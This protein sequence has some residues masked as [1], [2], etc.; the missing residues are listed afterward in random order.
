MLEIENYVCRIL[1]YG[2]LPISLR[3]EGV[4]Y[5]DVIHGWTENR[6]MSLGKTNAKKILAGFGISQTNPYLV[7]K[8]FHFASLTD[9]YWMMEEGE[10]VLWKDVSL[11]RNRLERAVSST[12][13]L[14]SARHFYGEKKRIRQ[15][16][17]TPELTAQG[18]S[19]KAW[20]RERGGMYL[21]KVGKKELAASRILD[22]LGIS[23]VGDE[24]V[25]EK[26]LVR[27]ADQKH[28]DKIKREQEKV[29]RCRMITSEQRAI[30]SWEDFQMYCA[31]HDIDEY[32][33]VRTHEARAYYSMQIADYILAY[34]DRHGANFGFF[35]NNRSGRLGHLYP[36]MDHDH[37]FSEEEPIFCQ[38]SEDEETLK[39]A[40][41][42]AA[43]QV[44]MAV[45][46]QRV[47][48]MGKPEEITD[49]Q[50]AGVLERTRE[51]VKEN[52]Q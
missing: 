10:E 46:Y 37:A 33:Y 18:M 1:D 50:W 22:A 19:A 26:R 41:L 51:L 35:M 6:T 11:F 9:C 38:T 7:A 24:E 36:L 30:V 12:A 31:Y 52:Y 2:R 28:V 3:Y 25:E 44:D 47:L 27:I 14:G 21:Y 34:E 29:V 15:K 39:E 42:Q 5:D 48:Q 4:N 43:K 32:A 49:Q 20:I 17:H 23:H 8:L 16:I 40:A 13:L 45:G